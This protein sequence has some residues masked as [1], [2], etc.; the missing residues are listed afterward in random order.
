MEKQNDTN[1]IQTKSP[2]FYDNLT[3]SLDNEIL[4]ALAYDRYKREKI[5]VIKDFRDSGMNSKN[6]DKKMKEWQKTECN[7][8]DLYIDKATSTYAKS[9]QIA[10]EGPS[11]ELAE[12]RNAFRNSVAHFCPKRE[13]RTSSFLWSVGAS[14][15]AWLI[16]I[17]I[18]LIAWVSRLP[19][20]TS[21]RLIALISG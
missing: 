4:I 17:L 10:L 7:K 2:H 5:K 13:T 8:V 20:G 12:E 11:K 18:V 9:M 15:V 1:P 14:V 3:A 6:I 16:T 19:K 21:D